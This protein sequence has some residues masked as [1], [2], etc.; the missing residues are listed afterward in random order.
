M[1]VF[2]FHTLVFYVF[3][4][5]VEWKD[6]PPMPDDSIYGPIRGTDRGTAKLRKSIESHLAT[7]KKK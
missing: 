3:D 1:L 7:P 6:Q 4:K 5:G 2:P